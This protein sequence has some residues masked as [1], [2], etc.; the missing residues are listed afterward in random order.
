MS[1]KIV[2]LLCILFCL[3]ACSD[4]RFSDSGQTV[5]PSLGEAIPVSL[6]LEVAPLSSPLS[7]I[8]RTGA[9]DPR[10]QASFSGMEVEL[11]GTPDVNTRALPPLKESE[12]FSVF[13]F[14]FDG[15]TSSSKSVQMSYIAAG[16]DGK[17]DL[18]SFSF[19]STGASMSRIVVV[20][21]LSKDY[22]NSTDWSGTN[23]KTYQELSDLFLKKTNGANDVYP[24]FTESGSS[25]N[26]G[27]MFGLSDTKIEAGK[28]ITV[29]LQRNFA[30]ASFKIEIDPTLQK[31]Y[32]I[33]QVHLANLPGRSYFLPVGR[34][35]PFPSIGSLGY[36]GYYETPVVSTTNGV[37]TNDLSVYLPVN[38]QP[39]VET[40]TEQTRT[41]Q[42]P[43]GSTYLQLI[44]LN[45]SPDG[46]ITNQVIYQIY[47]GANFTTNYT[48][49]HNTFYKYTI[50]VND[51]NPQDGTIIKFI[52]GYWAGKLMAYD[53]TN[54][55]CAFGDEKAV[56]WRYQKQIEVYPFDLNEVGTTSKRMYWG[57]DSNGSFDATSFVDGQL[58]T[59]NIHTTTPNSSYPAS[60]ACYLLNGQQ[61]S[62]K[63]NLIWYLPS[64]GQLMGTYIVCS[65]L[66]STLSDNYWSSTSLSKPNQAYYINKNGKVFWGAADAFLYVRPVKDVIPVN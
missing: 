28:Q 46:N 27:V 61:V 16:T 45:M 1:G 62:S 3:G 34:E 31:K 65:G 59:W 37:F 25:E 43:L 29:V 13:I 36:N 44:G 12:I 55:E 35:I 42:A 60:Y 21:N 54:G 57:P 2:Y 15:V 30:K 7:A 20:A 56:K 33:W 32:R 47:L 64:I 50:H 58:N 66:L 53:A 4:D 26:R 18:S 8:T 6:S 51:D 19:A 48:I 5:S 40:S 24:L 39:E 9:G 10:L 63:E 49:S 23:G 38:L 22:F 14:Q 11:S 17:I 52:A 41:L